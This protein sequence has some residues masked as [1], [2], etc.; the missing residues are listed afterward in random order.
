MA[1]EITLDFLGAQMERLMAEMRG[2]RGDIASL[3]DD[4]NV[5]TA[6]AMRQDGT[7]IGLQTEMRATHSQIQ[8][9]ERRVSRLEEAGRE[10]P[11]ESQ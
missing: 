8:R 6:I 5:L 3:R 4:I 10:S 7:L 2:V 1:A 9:I 11:P